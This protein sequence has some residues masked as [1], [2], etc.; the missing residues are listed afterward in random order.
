VRRERRWTPAG[1]TP[2]RKLGRFTAVPH[3]AQ[4]PAGETENRPLQVITPIFCGSE[5]DFADKRGAD[6]EEHLDLRGMG[7]DRGLGDH[8]ASQNWTG[9]GQSELLGQ[10]FR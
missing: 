1:A 2:A 4:R 8:V 5:Y 3:C 10:V 9:G 6:D 7:C